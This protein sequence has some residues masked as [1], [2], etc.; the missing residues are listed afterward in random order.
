MKAVTFSTYGTPDVLEIRELP[1]PEPGAGEVRVRVHSAAV[2]PTDAAFRA[3]AYAPLVDELPDVL[4]PFIPGMDASGFIDAVGPGVDDRLS[5]GEKVVAFVRPVSPQGGAYAEYVVLP[6]TSVVQAPRGLDLAASS[7]FLMNAMT[8]SAALEELALKPQDW[9]VVTGAPGMLGGYL[10]QLAKHQGLRVIA[11]AAPK[12][13]ELVTGFGAD[14]IVPRGDDFSAAVRASLPEG[15]HG[16]ADAG[17][18][19]E[20]AVPAVADDGVMIAFQGWQ[21]PVDRGIRLFQLFIAAW[22]DDTARMQSLVADVERGVIDI[23]LLESLAPEQASEAHRAMHAGG[24]RGRNV[25]TF[26]A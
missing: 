24:I 8:A 3:G 6:E 12:D 25:L 9:L 13:V 20:M 10:I 11:D 4:P 19:N 18:T 5:V 23:R 7:T 17:I 2:N 15:A 1:I 14:K 22:G 16:L 21:G 26:G